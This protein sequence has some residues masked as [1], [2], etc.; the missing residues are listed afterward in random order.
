MFKNLYKIIESQI[1]KDDAT[2]LDK[3]EETIMPLVR[4]SGISLKRN[5]IYEVIIDCFCENLSLSVDQ[6]EDYADRAGEELIT[7]RLI[8]V[9]DRR[10]K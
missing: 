5:D 8:K 7:A 10:I 4:E 6:G 2:Q 3:M 9:E 1:R